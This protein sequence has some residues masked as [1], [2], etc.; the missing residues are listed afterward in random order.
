[1]KKKIAALACCTVFLGS[2]ARHTVA[3]QD[4]PTQAVLVTANDYAF[5]ALPV[6][7]A[8]PAIFSFS[9]QGKVTHEMFLA[10]LKAGVSADEYLKASNDPFKRRDMSEEMVGILLAGPGKSPSG[11]LLVD[12]V[13]GATYVVG[14]NM[15]D[16]PDAPG[17]LTY[18]MLKT[19]TV[20]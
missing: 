7:K 11:K 19:F 3:A 20:K 16:K 18:G 4:P 1:M 13:P 10:R 9:N 5:L 6:I 15:R 2:P 12:L 8:G 14:C 17:H